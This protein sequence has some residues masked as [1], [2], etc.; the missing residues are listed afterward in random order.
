LRIFLADLHDLS[1]AAFANDFEEIEGIPNGDGLDDVASLWPSILYLLKGTTGEDIL[2]MDAKWKQVYAK[3]VYF[4]QAVSG[5]FLNEGKPAL[6]FSGRLMTGVIRLD[7][8]L[9]WAAL[10]VLIGLGILL[11]QIVAA[12]ERV[13]IRW[14][15][16][17]R[18]NDQQSFTS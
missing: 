10:L 12:I 16:S 11:F 2:A 15:V 17:V 6:F 14:H 5:N 8:T 13:A 1:K 3:Q 9:V 7:G 4:G 18:V